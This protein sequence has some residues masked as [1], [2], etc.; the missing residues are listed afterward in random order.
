M[1]EKEVKLRLRMDRTSVETGTP[2]DGHAGDECLAVMLGELHPTPLLEDWPQLVKGGFH[3]PFVKHIETHCAQD[4]RFAG[5]D[6]LPQP[7][8]ARGIDHQKLIDICEDDRIMI[9]EKRGV[10]IRDYEGSL[11]RVEIA[12]PWEAGN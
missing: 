5:G 1:E 3:L 12:T 10:E 11:G 4:G 6:E 2:A 9:A 8:G 7:S